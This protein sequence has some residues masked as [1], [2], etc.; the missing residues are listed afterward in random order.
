MKAAAAL[1]IIAIL[2]AC[3]V[4]PRANLA[5]EL[6]YSQRH[7]VERRSD[8]DYG[9]Q[10]VS[11]LQQHQDVERAYAIWS[12]RSDKVYVVV[13]SSRSELPELHKA[14]EN[15]DKAW[16]EVDLRLVLATPTELAM[17]KEKLATFYVR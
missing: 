16:P 3:S 8:T 1:P 2:A 17:L 4:S 5:E 9:R 6:D 12:A 13:D 7:P 10:I 15:L 14:I 11:V